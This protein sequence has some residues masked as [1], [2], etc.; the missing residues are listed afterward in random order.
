[1]YIGIIVCSCLTHSSMMRM[2]C[3]TSC[4][5]YPCRVQNLIFLWSY[6]ARLRSIAGSAQH[7]YSGDSTCA[8]AP[9]RS[10]GCD[11]RPRSRVIVFRFRERRDVGVACV[12]RLA[13][14]GCEW[15]KSGL[16]R[17]VSNLAFAEDSCPQPSGDS[18]PLRLLLDDSEV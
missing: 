14:R 2:T 8:A 3:P 6:T 9:R 4:S 5:L 13:G 11:G 12:R 16:R 1:M 15:L 18:A 10:G 7:G 17:R